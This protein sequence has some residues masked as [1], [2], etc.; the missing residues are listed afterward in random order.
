MTM[1]NIHQPWKTL[2][3]ENMWIDEIIV[4][5]LIKDKYFWVWQFWVKRKVN[6]SVINCA[7]VDENYVFKI[8][9]DKHNKTWNT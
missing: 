6:V 9:D 2:K 1:K 7:I 5:G 8:Q 4:I 3:F